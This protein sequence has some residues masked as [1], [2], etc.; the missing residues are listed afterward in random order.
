VRFIVVPEMHREAAEAAVRAALTEDG[1]SGSEFVF[2]L[3]HLPGGLGWRVHVSSASGTD[4]R[5]A[6]LI[7]QKLRDAGL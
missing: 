4:A 6:G 5:L 2:T 7:Q 1:M 3:I